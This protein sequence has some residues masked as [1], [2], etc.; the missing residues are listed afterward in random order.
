[1]SFEQARETLSWAQEALDELDEICC[2]FFQPGNS[3]R[4]TQFDIKKREYVDKEAFTSP[5]PRAQA[6]RK[7]TEAIQSV[8]NTF[9]QATH[10]CVTAIDQTLSEETI[11]F[12]WTDTPTGLDKRLNGK[13]CKIPSMLWETFRNLQPYGKGRGYSGGDDVTRRLAKMAN[14]KHTVGIAI[15]PRI[16]DMSY[17][18]SAAAAACLQPVPTWNSQRNE[19]EVMRYPPGPTPQYEYSIYFDV[20]FDRT[21]PLKEKR[22]LES[23]RRFATK[24]EEA[25]TSL[26]EAARAS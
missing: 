25:I 26:E 6:A 17:R 7:A 14:T 23:V 19:V 9:D 20:V 11:Y 5:F 12:P 8:K 1:M 21:T 24:A 10:A 13:S 22:V 3:K 2:R 18:V 15:R 4:I 16:A